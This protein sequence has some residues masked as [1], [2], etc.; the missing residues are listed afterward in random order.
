MLKYLNKL[1]SAE[2]NISPSNVLPSGKNIDES[3][4][5]PFSA[6]ARLSVHSN[7]HQRLSYLGDIYPDQSFG[8]ALFPLEQLLQVFGK[9]AD[10]PSILLVLVR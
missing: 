4:H 5:F 8:S 2:T 6:K 1:S 10:K 9:P 3:L 7:N